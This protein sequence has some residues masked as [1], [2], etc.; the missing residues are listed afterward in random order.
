LQRR[1]FTCGDHLTVAARRRI[2]ATPRFD[3]LWYAKIPSGS[4]LAE[5]LAL[6][7]WASL[8]SENQKTNPASTKYFSAGPTRCHRDSP[9]FDSFRTLSTHWIL[10]LSEPGVIGFRLV[11]RS[12]G[13]N[14]SSGHTV[15]TQRRVGGCEAC[16]DNARL[17]PIHG[18]EAVRLTFHREPFA[19]K[20]NKIS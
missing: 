11:P 17:A 20:D 14:R 3:S 13:V 10:C 5:M 1:A 8:C 15:K 7:C 16:M 9:C 6:I 18:I 4:H 12:V 2:A 19:F